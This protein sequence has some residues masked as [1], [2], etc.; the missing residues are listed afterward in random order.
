MRRSENPP[1]FRHGECQCDS[2]M[3]RKCVFCQDIADREEERAVCRSWNWNSTPR[4]CAIDARDRGWSQQRLESA[5]RNFGYEPDLIA[6]VVYE[7]E[8]EEG[9]V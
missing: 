4:E 1:A 2:T 7:F 6:Q 3:Y 5:M 9:F 8:L